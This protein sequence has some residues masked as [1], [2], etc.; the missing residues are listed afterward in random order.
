MIDGIKEVDEL[1]SLRADRMKLPFIE[2]DSGVGSCTIVFKVYW[3]S[4]E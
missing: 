1:L 4:V 2:M 3:M